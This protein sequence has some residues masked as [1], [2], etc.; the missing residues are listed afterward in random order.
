MRHK[1]T[2]LPITVPPVSQRVEPP[3]IAFNRSAAVQ[4]IEGHASTQSGAPHRANFAP[5]LAPMRCHASFVNAGAD[6]RSNR[7]A[8]RR[9]HRMQQNSHTS[10]MRVVE[11]S[12]T[13][14]Q[15][16]TASGV[17]RCVIEVG[18]DVGKVTVWAGDGRRRPCGEL[19]MLNLQQT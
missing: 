7:P 5:T 14:Q 4:T 16:S 17:L 19:R 1:W 12:I 6:R 10:K 8:A 13:R 11:P 15:I 9:S 2:K 18:H 3:R